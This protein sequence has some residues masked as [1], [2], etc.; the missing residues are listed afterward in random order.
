MNGY[1]MKI[2]DWFRSKPYWLKGGT[3]FIV[4]YIISYFLVSVTQTEIYGDIG[5]FILIFPYLVVMG[6]LDGI[7]GPN[8]IFDIGSFWGGADVTLIGYIIGGIITVFLVF[9]VG[10]LCGWL[11][12]LT[13]GKIKSKK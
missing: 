4:W 3:V 1:N 10:A 13:V 6:R 11:I 2:K 8:S 5:T 12:G 7:F 9:W